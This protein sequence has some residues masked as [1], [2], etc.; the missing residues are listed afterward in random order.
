MELTIEQALRQGI[1]AHKEGKIQEAERLYRAILKSQPTHPDANHNLGVLAVSV[2]KTE[3]SLPLFKTA[4]E[5]NPKIEQFW[6]SYIDGLIKLGM[7]NDAKREIKKFKKMGHKSARV[8]RWIKTHLKPINSQHVVLAI[9][10][11]YQNNKNRTLSAASQGWLFTEVFDRHFMQNK[12]STVKSE[13]EIHIPQE[14]K[15]SVGGEEN[16]NQ[17]GPREIISKLNNETD[18]SKKYSD[19]K[20]L[21]Y[22][23]DVNLINDSFGYEVGGDLQHAQE[24]TFN[25]EGFNVVI[26]GGGVCGLF[27]ANSIKYSFGVQANVLVLENRSKKINTREPFTREWLTHIQTNVFQKY[28]PENIRTLMQCFGTNR[29]IGVP[30]NIIEAILMLSCKD[31]GVKFYF[32]PRLEYSEI[33]NDIVDCVFDA[34]A[35]RLVECSYSTD[36]SK[37]LRVKIPKQKMNFK[38]AGVSPLHN[39]LS[40][41]TDHLDVILRP[42]GDFHFPY[43]R[44]LRIGTQMVKLTSVPLNLM[45]ITLKS[46][47]PVNSLNLFYVWGGDLRKEIN[48]GLIL[49][50]LHRKEY[51]FLAS[52]TKNPINLKT[53]L[54][55][56]PEITSHLDE[57]IIS[58]LEMLVSLDADRK[59]KIENPFNY[60]PYINLNADLGTLNGKRVFPIGDSLFC[61]H[62][63]AGNGLAYH[64]KF[65]HELLGEIIKESKP[66]KERKT[67]L[68]KREKLADDKRKQKVQRQEAKVKTPSKADLNKLLQHYQTGRYG[69]AKNLALSITQKFPEHQFSWKVLGALF[70]Q[71]GRKDEALNANQ[72]A[73]ELEPDDSQAHNNLG[74]AL[75]DVDKL[76]EAEASY[77]KAIALKSDFA[78]PHNNLG[79]ALKVVGR[80]EEAEASYRK[81][82]ALKPDYAEPHNNL[83]DVLKDLGRL[84]EAK[85]SLRKAI[86]LNSDYAAAKHL[87]AALTGET[88][89][90]PP[91]IYVEEL[92]DNYASK[93]ESALVDKLE[94]K[95]PK[96][97]TEM[98]I[99][100]HRDGSLGSVL[101]LGCGTG[102]VGVEIKE[103]CSYLEGIDLSNSMLEQAK[104]KNVY[105]KLTYRDITEYLTTENLDFDYF[106]S[107]DVF[108]Y[109]G[110]LSDVF[111]LIKSRNKSG[112]K[113]VF[114]TENTDKEGFFLEQSGRYSHSKQYIETLCEKYNYKLCHFESQNLRKEKNSY[115]S[116]D[117]YLLDF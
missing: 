17:L 62:P 94:Y 99:K 32:S 95:I 109:L 28:T 115:I 36:N 2:N 5:A 45:E 90:A 48:E 14:N 108:V 82:I 59:I 68:E 93:F 105:D 66:N 27:L 42:D 114:S 83:G 20:A 89:K 39:K 65:I 87:L 100:D 46:I 54:D 11:F 104:R 51:E 106:I 52:V 12:L 77:R 8:D 44:D 71:E 60:R 30:I 6:L 16:I 33:N 41:E 70:G 81:A 117:L 73:V 61:G 7:I 37:E 80:L 111:K 19:L 91:R 76:E 58:V 50:N 98:I 79:N 26:I 13:Q 110:D 72:K 107:T 47:E 15:L 112:G 9:E 22:S 55:D 102:L 113:L 88:T 96:I 3:E 18:I 75:K 21:I 31:Q 24:K 85:T 84:E 64:L 69:D 10:K 34:T 53:F 67:F 38:Y 57:N 78:E 49:I 25:V 116:G 56:N 35:G 23:N 43:I 74:N 63:K 97:I 101:D 29:L 86:A 1:A 92:F 103:F 4:I 40:N